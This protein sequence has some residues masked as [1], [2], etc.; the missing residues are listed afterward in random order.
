MRKYH[1]VAE[2]V[3]KFRVG[4]LVLASTLFVGFLTSNAGAAPSPATPTTMPSATRK[5]SLPFTFSTSKP[6]GP[7][8]APSTEPAFALPFD[9]SPT[10]AM[11][12]TT[13][14]TPA[15]K[16][17][18]VPETAPA[19][20]ATSPTVV[21]DPSVPATVPATAP[22]VVQ[23]PSVPATVPATAPMVVQGPSVPVT[24]P[25]TIPAVAGPASTSP[26]TAP[27]A[28][29]VPSTTQ[30][31]VATTNPENERNPLVKSVV[32]NHAFG[33]TPQPTQEVRERFNKWVQNVAD[34][35]NTLDLVVGKP[36]ILQLAQAPQKVQIPD[37]RVAAYDVLSE[38]ELSVTGVSVGTT[39]LN[40]WFDDKDAPSG[41]TLLSYYVRVMTDPE[42]K[43]RVDKIY[44]ALEQKIN[45]A[46]PDSQVH[47]TLVGR[48]LV[49]RGEAKDA[50][51]ANDIIRLLGNNVVG[52]GE[53]QAARPG[54]VGNAGAADS[55]APN[56]PDVV[57]PQAGGTAAP[58]PTDVLSLANN[59]VSGGS[60]A[61]RGT[62]SSGQRGGGNGF[63]INMLRVPGE[64]QVMLR[65]TV[66][67]VNR[68]A[69]RSIGLN[70]TVSGSKGPIFA[71]LTGGLGA[72][73]SG[74]QGG[75]LPMLL[76]NGQLG[77]PLEALR[78]ISLAKSLAEPNLVAVN[79]QEAAFQAGGKFPVPVVT[80]ATSTGLQGVQYIPFGVSLRFTPYITEKDQI[81]LQFNAEVSTRDATTGTSVGGSTV[82]GISSRNV[83]TTVDLK[84]GQT[85]AV[86]GLIQTNYG[87]GSNRIPFFGE[88]PFVANL[89]GQSQ[90]SSSEQ[91]L[92][93]LINAE[94]IRPMNAK[95]VPPLPGHDLYEASDVEFFLQGRLES[96]DGPDFR[97]PTR[98]DWERLTRYQRLQRAYLFGTAGYSDGRTGDEAPHGAT[99]VVDAPADHS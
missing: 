12:P 39:V 93:I 42:T 92:V 7:T 60:G 84:P 99:R 20:P 38:K 70:F 1:L 51:E 87:S 63:I 91:E 29:T 78:S 46:F 43:I 19:V 49:V 31:T 30:T 55:G 90:S 25:A 32:E 68:D 81:R 79:G 26:A 74:A 67:E 5:F 76:D 34:P 44:V 96:R 62:P 94:L 24:V 98:T 11:G 52:S 64:N 40:L 6:A 48:N 65:V 15:P 27:V 37:E 8:T 59:G 2:D 71:N 88:M 9:F 56:A 3:G 10:K 18:R 95:S 45:E 85:L 89:L 77:V 50:R 54:F 36:R 75:Q 66:A 58:S 73:R 83:Q 13:L 61:G 17:A 35:E 47:L 72:F 53:L 80:G 33:T 69:A 97:S 23:G 82:A 14:P 86:A 22:T 16:L 21:Q 57:A 4:I 28:T 41:R